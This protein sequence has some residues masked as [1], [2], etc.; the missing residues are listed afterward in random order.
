MFAGLGL[1]QAAHFGAQIVKVGRHGNSAV[2]F[3]KGG[4]R[5]QLIVFV[6]GN[7]DRA[8]KSRRRDGATV[9][10]QLTEPKLK[11][12]RAIET[13]ISPLVVGRIVHKRE[14]KQLFLKN[15]FGMQESE[16]G[17]MPFCRQSATK[18]ARQTETEQSLF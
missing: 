3:P 8:A 5:E 2:I 12:K 7:F 14:P 9:N 15:Q 10:G 6:F 13:R 16:S 18:I 11:R 4:R 17:A 1:L